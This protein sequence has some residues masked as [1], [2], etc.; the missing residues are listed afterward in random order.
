MNVVNLVTA[1]EKEIDHIRKLNN[2]TLV[3]AAF[4]SKCEWNANVN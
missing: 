1:I 4:H 3:R 2:Y